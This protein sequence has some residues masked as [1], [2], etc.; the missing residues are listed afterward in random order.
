[1][2][3]SE[4]SARYGRE[5]GLQLIELAREIVAPRYPKWFARRRFGISA[6]RLSDTFSRF[7]H[8]SI[9]DHVVT[10]L[11]TITPDE[12]V[13]TG[14]FHLLPLD[15]L[16][17]YLT[18]YGPDGDGAIEHGWMAFSY[19]TGEGDGDTWVFDLQRGGSLLSISHE[20]GND[21]TRADQTGYA[22]AETL[23]DWLAFLRKEAV[24]RGW[25]A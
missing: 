14:I 19:W 1:M 6:E 11:E 8:Y 10:F 20:H 4:Y 25:L 13:D 12:E 9:P 2:A 7:T 21:P 17:Q 23:T 16:K 5:C 18:V 3:T 15:E 24:R 22:H